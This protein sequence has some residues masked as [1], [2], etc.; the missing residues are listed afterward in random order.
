[1]A[2]NA[3]GLLLSIL[4]IGIAP[5]ICEEILFRGAVMRGFERFGTVK[6]IL[7]SSLLFGL[8]HFDFQKL[9]GTFLLGGLIGFIVYRTDSIFGGMVAHFTNNSTAV[10]LMFVSVKLQELVKSPGAG[11]G[12]DAGAE[13][14]KYLATLAAL[15]KAQLAVI[16]A[17]WVFII[18]F[19]AAVFMGLIIAL[20]H[21]T[22]AASD[23]TDRTGEGN[24]KSHALWLLPGVALI[25]FVYFSQGLKLKGITLEPVKAILRIIGLE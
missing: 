4:A 12:A 20:I 1:V 19:C 18:L 8:M 14:D 24:K 15:P 3:A 25:S 22:R 21:N 23:I 11:G 7:A 16:I 10:L 17:V 6:A 13:F 9:L 5:A 2:D